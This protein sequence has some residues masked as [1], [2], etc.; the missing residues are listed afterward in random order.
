MAVFTITGDVDPFLHVSL[1][2]GE[3][4]SCESDAMVMMEE[5]LDLT[6]RMQG[7]LLQAMMRKLTNG[8]SFFQQHIKAVRGDGDCLLSPNLPG[9]MQILDVGKVQY[10]ISDE[11]YVAATDG[12]QVTAQMQ[13][14]GTALFGGTGGFFIGRSSGS[15]Q[16]VVSGFGA[17]FS[18]DVSPEKNVIIDNGHVVAWDS[19]L[20]YELSTSTSQGQGL[21][22]SLVNSVT[23][24]EG[25]VLKFSGRGQVIVC[26]RNRSGF[27]TWLGAK[28]GLRK[29]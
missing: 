29:S 22:N 18:I 4:I 28:L 24:G 9:A 2:R 20:H 5:A 14:L 27:L 15:G 3:S 16:L 13:S 7:G 12:V 25:L 17:I 26:S 19:S 8:E 1:R 6:G 10:C 21:L 23:S 11:A